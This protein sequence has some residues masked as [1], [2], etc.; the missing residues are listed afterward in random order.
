L[1]ILSFVLL[2]SVALADALV[3]VNVRDG[4]GRPVEGHV[5][6]TAEVGGQTY[7]CQ[8]QGGKCEIPKVPGGSYKASVVPS[9]STQATPP[10]A[11]MIPPSGKVSLIVSTAAP[12]A[13]P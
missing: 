5:S 3:V 4:A 10:R 1:L 2:A 12:V 13:A 8:T 6:L 11:V 7:G 9:G